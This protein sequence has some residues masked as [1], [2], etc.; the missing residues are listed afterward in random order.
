MGMDGFTETRDIAG[1]LNPM[2]LDFLAISPA[3]SFFL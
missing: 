2:N 1:I 3:I